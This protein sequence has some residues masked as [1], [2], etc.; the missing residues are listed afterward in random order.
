MPRIFITGIAGFLGSH[1][2]EMYANKGWDVQGIDNF[3]CSTPERI[4]SLQKKHSSLIFNRMDCCSRQRLA[5]TLNIF[6]PD[7]LVHAAATAH[8]GLSVF[9][10]HEITRNIF[11][12]STSVFSAAIA[13]GV[14]SIVYCSSMARYGKQQAPF[15]EDME[16]KPVDP[17]G[18]AKVAVEKVLVSLQKVHKFNARII[19]PHN[20][21]GEGQTYD[22][23]YRN[24]VAIMINR[25][26]QDKQPV[27]YGDGSQVRC[28]SYINDVLGC[29]E[30]IIEDSVAFYNKNYDIGIP[31]INIGPDEG[32]MTILQLAQEIAKQ[33]NF[34]LDSIFLKGRPL[35]VHHATC[36]SEKI[37]R[38]YAYKTEYTTEQAIAAMIEDIKFRGPKPFRYWT[39]PEIVNEKTPRT[40]LNDDF[41]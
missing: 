21:V 13:A 7:I 31:V 16:P 2:A 20:I 22:D 25:M 19:V 26:L 9:S 14:P 35:E 6:K 1:L 29:F 34:T 11:E 17:Y 39:R 36:S 12:A 3:I 38:L 33:L 18:I 27:I 24:V 37:K 23:P 40:W 30:K 15:T 28:F 41:I 8:E 5:A 10:P 4:E 32:E